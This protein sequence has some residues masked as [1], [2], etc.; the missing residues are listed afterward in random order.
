MQQLT[1]GT[2]VDYHGSIKE[3]RGEATVHGPCHCG[4][5]LTRYFEGRPV[6][7]YDLNTRAGFL[8]HVRAGSLY[9]A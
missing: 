9:P 5:C 6:T 1:P 8:G 3:A 2:K 4:S 7:R